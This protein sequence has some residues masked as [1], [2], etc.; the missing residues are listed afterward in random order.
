MIRTAIE[1]ALLLGVVAPIVYGAFMPPGRGLALRAAPSVPAPRHRP[2][3]GTHCTACGA[4]V[5]GHIDDMLAL[6]AVV[7]CCEVCGSALFGRGPAGDEQ[8]VAAFR[9]QLDAGVTL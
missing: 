6:F 1:A 3:E 9:R 2:A 8:L 5:D 7:S 4:E